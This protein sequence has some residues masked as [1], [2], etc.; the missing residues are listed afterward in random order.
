MP[1]SGLQYRYVGDSGLTEADLDDVQLVHV[2]LGYCLMFQFNDDGIKD[3]YRQTVTHQGLL[4]F[5]FTNDHVIGATPI[6]AP[7]SDGRLFTFV[8]VPDDKL[9]DLVL[10]LQDSIKKIKA[11]KDHSN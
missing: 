11:L 10:D 3:L 7:I 4:L 6:S 1:I 5:T 2:D 8:E 9:G